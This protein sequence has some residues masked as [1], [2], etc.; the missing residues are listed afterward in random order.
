MP[1][2][3]SVDPVRVKVVPVDVL[4]QVPDEGVQV[5]PGVGAA[6]SIFAVNVVVFPETAFEGS[7][8][9]TYQDV[10]PIGV[11]EPYV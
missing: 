4:C 1:L 11:S 5:A 6:V 3:A 2:K 9:Y 8:A 7:L 10:P